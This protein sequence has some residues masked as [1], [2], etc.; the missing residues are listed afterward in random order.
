MQLSCDIKRSS[1]LLLRA[2]VVEKTSEPSVEIDPRI[3]FDFGKDDFKAFVICRCKKENFSFLCA[4]DG[5]FV[6]YEPLSDKN[7]MHAWV[8]ASTM[9][10]GMI[11]NVYATMASQSVHKELMLPGVMM[12]DII[13]SKIE[14]LSKEASKEN[15]SKES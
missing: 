14:D 10:Y 15:N 5:E 3:Q 9:L 6:F 4:M 8:N 11:R 7:I 12:H 2:E 13:K 1:I